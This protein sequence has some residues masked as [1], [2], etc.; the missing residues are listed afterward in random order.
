ML[1]AIGAY[2][3][4]TIGVKE[5]VEAIFAAITAMTLRASITK[6]TNT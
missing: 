4:G 2:L 6:S 5:L 3:S 1:T